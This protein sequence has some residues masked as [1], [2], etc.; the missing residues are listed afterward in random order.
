MFTFSGN[1]R[2]RDKTKTVL[3]SDNHGEQIRNM[4]I[5]IFDKTIL[6]YI[7]NSLPIGHV[8]LDGVASSEDVFEVL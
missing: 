3:E 6:K 1:N 2:A 4:H 7:P 8:P 5:L